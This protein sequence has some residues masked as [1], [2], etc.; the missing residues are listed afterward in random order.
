MNP[1]RAIGLLAVAVV[2]VA[3]LALGVG[4][5]ALS[6]AEVLAALARRLGFASSATAREELIVCS[7]RLPRIVLAIVVGAALAGAGAGLQGLV[8]NPLADP[9]LIGVSNGAALAAVAFI[10]LGHALV[11][12]LPSSMTPWLL[13]ASAFAG[14]LVAT[15]LAVT[16]ARRNGRISPASL[17][18]AGVGIASLAGAGVGM[19]LFVADDAQLRS[20]TFWTLGSLGAASWKLVGVVALPVAVGL[21]ILV[22]HRDALDRLLLGEAEARHLGIEPERVTRRVIVAVALA[23]GAAVAACGVIGFVGLVVPHLVR[24]WLGPSHRWL[25]PASICGGAVLLL[26]G[27][28]IARV[29]VAPAELPVGIVTALAGAPVLLVMV[30]RGQVEVPS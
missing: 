18:L 25:L 14:A 13:P 15:T 3:V 4:A 30:I 7:L 8:R 22:A 6:P 2:V 20:V 1:R 19:L 12:A 27:D 28:T 16:L 17:V 21:A 29:I 10:V 5:V 11:V 24:G 23:V 9:A 26:A